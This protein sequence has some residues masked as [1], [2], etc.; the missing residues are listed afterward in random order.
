MKRVWWAA[1]IAVLAAALYCIL[2]PGGSHALP[3]VRAEGCDTSYNCNRSLNGGCHCSADS[4]C[5][6]CFRRNNDPSCGR[7][8]DNAEIYE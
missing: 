3:V 7:C 4:D 2:S 6:G 5:S 8:A 1:K